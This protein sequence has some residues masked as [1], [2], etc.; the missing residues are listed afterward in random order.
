[1]MNA[2]WS[3][4]IHVE[5]L[6]CEFIPPLLGEEL[7][8]EHRGIH[9][10]QHLAAQEAWQD[11]LA[12]VEAAWARENRLESEQPSVRTIMAMNTLLLSLRE[13]ILQVQN[14]AANLA[15]AEM[16]RRHDPA[17]R[18]ALPQ[19][20]AE[21]AQRLEALVAAGFELLASAQARLAQ[22]TGYSQGPAG[23]GLRAAR[24]ERR[25]YRAVIDFPDRRA[26]G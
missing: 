14:E 13:R 19:L 11:A 22:L 20:G 3:E 9:W 10:E 8:Q 15:I 7:T 24:L 5:T 6:E 18:P 16:S 17:A 23:A 1:M 25:T 21:G 12:D 2:A 4:T 26:A